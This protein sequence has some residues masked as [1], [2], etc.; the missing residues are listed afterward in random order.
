MAGEG[1]PD[2]ALEAQLREYYDKA[3]QTGRAGI[4][5]GEWRQLTAE[6]KA[7]HIVRLL[8][9][10][11]IS[12]S[13]VADVGCG[14]GSVLSWLARAGVGSERVGYEISVA[15]AELARSAAGVD[16]VV[17]FD[18]RRLP[19]ADDA[20]DLVVCS[21]VLEHTV[22]PESFVAELRRVGRTVIIE[23]PLESNLLALRPSARAASEAAGHRHRFSRNDVTIMTAAAGLQIEDEILDPLPRAVFV[24]GRQ[25]FPSRA[26]GTVKWAM[27]ALFGRLPA[28]PMLLT[29]H[30][31]LL[32]S[33]VDG[34]RSTGAE[35]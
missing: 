6:T 30:Y 17:V 27:R 10:C 3:Y 12:V 28:A 13:T 19:V 29:L 24:W 14:D 32:A 7:R 9:R 25:S 2:R 8:R 20:F 18:G 16:A 5:Y 21:H 26:S 35:L 33:R 23:V 1:L 4:H 15:A 34:W 22:H 31:A 11:G